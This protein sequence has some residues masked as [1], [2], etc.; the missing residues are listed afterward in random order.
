M[1]KIA[2]VAFALLTFASLHAHAA[3]P[4][5]DPDKPA[6]CVVINETCQEACKARPHVGSCRF[7]CAGHEMA[8]FV[9]PEAR[10]PSFKARPPVGPP[11]RR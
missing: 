4:S 5:F 7:Q 11:P 8:C 10:R 9:T 1:H 2:A 6:P 3:E